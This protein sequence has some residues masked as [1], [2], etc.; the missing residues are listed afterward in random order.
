MN[1]SIPKAPYICLK[2][3]HVSNRSLPP[4]QVFARIF[5]MGLYFFA[6]RDFL[7]AIPLF[8]LFHFSVVFAVKWT[9]E[10]ARHTKGGMLT[11]LVSSVNV[12]ASSLVYVRIVPIEKARHHG[13]GHGG[14]KKGDEYDDDDE[15]DCPNRASHAVEQVGH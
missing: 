8:L 12:F 6:A 7:P 14:R 9:F 4:L 15:E 11:W 13:H 10:R 1:V 3:G 2:Q 5:S